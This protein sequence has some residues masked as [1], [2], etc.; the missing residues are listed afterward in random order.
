MGTAGWSKCST[1]VEIYIGMLKINVL[2]V[3]K[4][5]GCYTV[6]ETDVETIETYSPE[7][8]IQSSSDRLRTQ[9]SNSELSA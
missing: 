7:I 2:V 1:A 3:H 5:S 8:S 6:L 9:S 4:L